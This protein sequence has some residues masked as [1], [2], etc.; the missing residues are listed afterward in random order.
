MLVTLST[1]RPGCFSYLHLP[2]GLR[3]IALPT[4]EPTEEEIKKF[5]EIQKANKRS[6]GSG[7]D[8]AVRT[9]R[10]KVAMPMMKHKATADWQKF[11]KKGKKKL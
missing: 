7:S 2:T 1:V 6:S 10:R 9:K 3:Q 11:L 4:R 8:D 5:I